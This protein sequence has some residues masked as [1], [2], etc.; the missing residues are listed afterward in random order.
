MVF[1]ERPEPFSAFVL[2]KAAPGRSIT[3]SRRAQK[4]DASLFIDVRGDVNQLIYKISNCSFGKFSHSPLLCFRE[5]VTLPHVGC[6]RHLRASFR[7][8]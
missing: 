4:V 7:S 2:C 3:C 8:P 1:G 5:F 6:S